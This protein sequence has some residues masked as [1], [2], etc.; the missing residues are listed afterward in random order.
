MLSLFQ[1]ELKVP[2]LMKTRHHPFQVKTVQFGSQTTLGSMGSQPF[3]HRSGCS[4]D[5]A[6]I[7]SPLDFAEMPSQVAG[8]ADQVPVPVVPAECSWLTQAQGAGAE[9]PLPR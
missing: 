7:Y 6:V 9:A 4:T 5:L 8:S 1:V 2:C 3:H